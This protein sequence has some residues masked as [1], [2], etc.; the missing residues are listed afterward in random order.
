M[1]MFRRVYFSN[2]GT[3]PMIFGNWLLCDSRIIKNGQKTFCLKHGYHARM[4]VKN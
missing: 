1:K 2:D 3:H 4:E